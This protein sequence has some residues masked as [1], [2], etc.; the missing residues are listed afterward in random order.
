[1]NRADRAGPRILPCG[2][3]ALTVEFGAEISPELNA[4]AVALG[5]ALRGRPGVIAV[6][7]TYRS[8]L[9]QYDPF[10]LSFEELS[11]RAEG[12]SAEEPVSSSEPRPVAELPVCYHPSLGP[13]LEE[14]AAAKGLTVAEVIDL[15][16]APV[17][18][19]YMLGFTPGFLFL[20]GLDPRLHAPRLP[21]PRKRV[22]PGSV[23]I[24]GA[25]TG[26]Y[27]LASPGGWRLIGR[28]PV[29]LFDPSRDPPVAARPGMGVRFV[30]ISLQE[31]ERLA[32]RS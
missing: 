14:L 29:K 15:H 22:P 2:D 1:V 18:R 31:Y 25:Q 12:L 26:A 4:R 27:A 21:E 24:A 8:L 11:L 5:N 10:E 28:T 17:Y 6:V 20:G 23:G 9:V 30:R 7:P 32:V 19:V 3:G 13:D 16:T